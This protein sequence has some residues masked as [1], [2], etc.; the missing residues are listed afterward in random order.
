M[1]RALD[2]SRESLFSDEEEEVTR[3]IAAPLSR[4]GLTSQIQ[5]TIQEDV[6][7]Y[8]R[9]KISGL[10]MQ[11]DFLSLLIEENNCVTWK[12][13]IWSVPRGVAKFAIN[14]GL[15]TLPSADNLKRWGKR[16]SDLCTVCDLS[17]KQTLNHILS[18]CS[19]ALEQ[20]RYTWRHNSVL[21]TIH[22][23]VSSNLKDDYEMFTDLEGLDAGNGGTI[24]PDVLV[25]GQRPDIFLVSR[26]L[27]KVIIFELTVPWDANVVSSHDLKVRKYASLVN[28][29]SVDYDVEMFCFEVSVR[30]Q[31]S[32]INKARLKSFLF[33]ITGQKRPSAVKLIN[34]VSKAALLGSFSIFTA[35]NEATWSVGRDLSVNV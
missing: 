13:F 3:A 7:K 15:N 29:L 19:V 30:G 16:T 28:D 8:W 34:N 35:R 14:A 1:D 11:G 17:R 18:Y 2:M 4:A 24:P 12:G 21:R 31:V 6:D 26:R 22:G 5:Q 33:M 27:R 25:T 20:G 10:L 9:E 32:K 23:F